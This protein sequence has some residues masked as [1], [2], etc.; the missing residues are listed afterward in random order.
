[1]GIIDDL[2]H[3]NISIKESPIMIDNLLNIPYA[4]FGSI[5]NTIFNVFDPF[6]EQFFLN[7][8][9]I[10]NYFS[11]F[12]EEARAFF[13]LTDFNQIKNNIIKILNFSSRNNTDTLD[14]I[15]ELIGKLK[16]SRPDGKIMSYEVARS[17]ENNWKNNYDSTEEDSNIT[18]LSG[19]EFLTKL[20]ENKP[21]GTK[22]EKIEK[23][24]QISKVIHNFSTNTD[25]I[26]LLIKSKYLEK[27]YNKSISDVIATI[28]SSIS[29]EGD[30]MNTLRIIKKENPG[31]I[32][33]GYLSEEIEYS[34]KNIRNIKSSEDL[35]FIIDKLLSGDPS[36]NIRRFKY[37]LSLANDY[38][39][40]ARWLEVSQPKVKEVFSP[41]FSTDTFRFRVLGNM[42]PY[43]F[44]V[45]V[46]TNC[47]QAIGGAGEASAIDSFINP[48]AG[49]LLLEVK[50]KSGD[51][52]RL[53]AQ[54]YFHF[55]EVKDGTEVKKAILLDNI[56]AG[57]LQDLYQK[58]NFYPNAYAVLGDYLKNSGFDIVG[59]G[60]LYT[61]V[62]KPKD[63]EGARLPEDPRHFEIEKHSIGRYSDFDSNDFLDLLKPRFSVQ[64]PENITSIDSEMSVKSAAILELHFRKFGN[65]KIDYLYKLSRSLYIQ[66]YKAEALYVNGLITDMI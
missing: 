56:E 27:C 60:L 22:K 24:F 36:E 50:S 46:D 26:N 5:N 32:P 44:R 43:H 14:G 54:S 61:E 65:K 3:N 55:A 62:I 25:F 29:Y 53:A 16:F 64:I 38:T 40:T 57:R 23:F 48:N 47:C 20:F 13:N 49:V 45:G 31:L 8:R 37:L 28:G 6:F 11:V 52:W 42:D 39:A 7:F 4:I 34:I 66:G 21:I 19:V 33:E 30:P 12:P 63:F 9:I 18:K 41:S 59:C 2:K 51:G 1:M 17:I 10:T 58:D 35:D 15:H